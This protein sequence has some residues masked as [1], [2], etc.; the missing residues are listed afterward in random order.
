MKPPCNGV[1]GVG[2]L[3]AA[4]R[5]ERDARDVIR[6]LEVERARVAGWRSEYVEQPSET[7][8]IVRSHPLIGMNKVTQEGCLAKLIDRQSHGG[9][10]PTAALQRKERQPFGNEWPGP[11]LPSW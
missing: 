11:G 2:V 8:V 5:G 6:R 9:P 10:A 4:D 7:S 3:L 1:L